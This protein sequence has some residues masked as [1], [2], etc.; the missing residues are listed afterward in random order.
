MWK[1]M[2][3]NIPVSNPTQ[4]EL[5]KQPKEIYGKLYIHVVLYAPGIMTTNTI[6][7]FQ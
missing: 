1:M 7:F 6:F 4:Q 3:M 2:K 5:R